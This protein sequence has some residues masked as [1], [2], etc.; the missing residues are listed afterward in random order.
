MLRSSESAIRLMTKPST[1]SSRARTKRRRRMRV[2]VVPVMS[3]CPLGGVRGDDV[4]FAGEASL[5]PEL[6]VLNR[7]GVVSRPG[8]GYPHTGPGRVLRRCG[9][10]PHPADLEE[11]SPAAGAEADIHS[12][13][14][15]A[16]V[17]A[18]RAERTAAA[19]ADR[20]GGRLDVLVIAFSTVHWWPPR[21]PGNG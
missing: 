3:V 8:C 15:G 10:N 17:A 9:G 12:A 4:S 2:T 16:G 7:P 18:V 5:P 14:A 1:A 11:G 13:R 6:G 19:R 20:H 21:E